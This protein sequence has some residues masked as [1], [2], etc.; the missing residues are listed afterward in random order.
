MTSQTLYKIYIYIY[1]LY[2][3]KKVEF[4]SHD[5]VKS[6][7]SLISKLIIYIY[8]YIKKKTH[9]LIEG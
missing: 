4:R 7:P 1:I 3:I 8:I 5:C 2:Y 6:L 9:V